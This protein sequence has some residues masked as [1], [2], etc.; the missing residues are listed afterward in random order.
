MGA[1]KENV[2]MLIPESFQCDLLGVRVFVDVIKLR[3]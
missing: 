3:T 1:P 2:H